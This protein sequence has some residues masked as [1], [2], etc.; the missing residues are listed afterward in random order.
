MDYELAVDE[1]K[2]IEAPT[3]KVTLLIVPVAV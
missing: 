2:I 3:V 1:V